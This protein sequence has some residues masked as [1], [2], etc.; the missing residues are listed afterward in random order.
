MD[1]DGGEEIRGLSHA[2]VQHLVAGPGEEEQEPV[3]RWR[4]GSKEGGSERG[5]LEAK[6][7][8]HFKKHDWI[9]CLN[10]AEGLQMRLRIAHWDGIVEL[11]SDLDRSRFHG[12]GSGEGR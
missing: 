12:V 11:I 3:R 1:V 4:G 10:T 2:G 5:V 6:G 8:K 7:S 9:D